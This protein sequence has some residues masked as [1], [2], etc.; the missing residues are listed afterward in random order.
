MSSKSLNNEKHHQHQ[1]AAAVLHEDG[2]ARKLFEPIPS[3]EESGIN[4]QNMLASY[5]DN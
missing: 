5:S 2:A 4:A 3:A 1:L